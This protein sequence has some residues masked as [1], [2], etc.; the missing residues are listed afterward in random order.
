LPLQDAQALEWHH[1]LLLNVL[2]HNYTCALR[3]MLSRTVRPTTAWP[4]WW[5]ILNSKLVTSSSD[6]SF[7]YWD[8]CVVCV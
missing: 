1:F 7:H 5:M 4:T 3:R 2:N 8:L 6:A